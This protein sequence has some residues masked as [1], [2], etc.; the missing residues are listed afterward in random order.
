MVDRTLGERW[1]LIGGLRLEHANMTVRSNKATGEHDVA[2]LD[3]T[4]L[5]PALNLQYRINDDQQLRLGVS[6]TLSRPDYREISP[7]DFPEWESRQISFGNPNLERSLI[8]N[9]DARWEW[10]PGTEELISIGVSSKRHSAP[11]ERVEVATSGAT[12]LS[13]AN[14]SSGYNYGLELE[15]RK[16]LNVI[17]EPLDQFV[18]FA[19]ATFMKSGVD[20]SN[21][22]TTSATNLERAMV[23]QAPYVVNV[24]IN[25]ANESGSASGTLL[26]NVVGKRI[27]AAG[28][29]PL[30][31]VFERP[32]NVLDGSVQ[33]PLF[34]HITVKLDAKNLLDA[35]YERV[36]GAVVRER[37]TSGRVFSFGLR[38]K[39]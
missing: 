26:Y 18:L 28:V 12:Q 14:A 31:D 33:L 4:D 3:N 37:Y 16:R 10:Y 2:E 15:V 7:T 29:A 23:G 38:W 39:P 32:R 6:Q 27:Y 22:G 24:G 11:I 1:R 20:I 25:Y 5:L 17:A 21:N 8:Q 34:A 13:F 30:P 36:Q 9:Y 35:P 19:N